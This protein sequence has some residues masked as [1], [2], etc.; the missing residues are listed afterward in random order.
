MVLNE[1][2]WI[3]ELREKRIAYGIS[4]GRLAVASG[5]TR[6]YLNK[7]ESGK[8]KPSKELLETLHK[9]LARFNP[10]APLTML[11][12]YVKIRFPTL[13]IQ[14][15][16]KD[17]LKL[18]INYMLHEDYG[19]YSYTEHYSLGDIF[20]YTS[21]DE[22]KGVLLELKGR[23]CRQFESYLLAQQRSWYD[24]LMDALVDGGVMKRIDLAINDHT[25][26][27]VQRQVAP[28]LKML[29]KIDKGNGTDYMETIEQQAKLTEKHE[30]IIKQQTTPAKDLVES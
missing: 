19:H 24:F 21:A 12:D 23:G 2:Q 7:I 26:R 4:Q 3:K 10:E 8:M 13:N 1:E 5:I 20:I 6:E 27:W 16:I 14:H 17:I 18:N 30:M 15:I 29:K 25:L 11:F 9:E 28:T 22:E